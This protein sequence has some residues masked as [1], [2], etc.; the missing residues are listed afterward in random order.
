MRVAA[1]YQRALQIVGG[2]SVRILESAC[3]ARGDVHCRFE[4][5]W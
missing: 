4:V 2:T 1:F 5:S 3:Q